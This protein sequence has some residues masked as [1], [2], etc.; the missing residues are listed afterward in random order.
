MTKSRLAKKIIFGLIFSIIFGF[1]GN[2]L[3]GKYKIAESKTWYN[4]LYILDITNNENTSKIKNVGI[5][6]YTRF[7]RDQF[8]SSLQYTLMIF[9]RKNEVPVCKAINIQTV[10]FSIMIESGKFIESEKEK[11]TFCFSKILSDSFKRFKEKLML[12]V[13]NA[14]M[15]K[16]VTLNELRLEIDRIRLQDLSEDG[17]QLNLLDSATPVLEK[18]F[19]KDI[20]KLYENV[21]ADVN[22]Y[23]ET[24][25]QNRNLESPIIGNF[26]VLDTLNRLSNECSKIL[27]E[28]QYAKLIN[29]LTNQIKETR[30][31][32]LF[33][34]LD[35]IFDVTK[36]SIKLNKTRREIYLTKTQTVATFLILGFIVGFILSANN[37]VLLNRNK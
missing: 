31:I 37:L 30:D 27:S 9:K 34:A 22:I 7:V 35:Q 29:E 2:F 1:M 21:I 32:I 12:I 24:N 25:N 13:E 3:H 23:L 11:L 33:T 28:N 8:F 14:L 18:S 4:E 36:Q 20:D 26:L 15:S 17:S 6:N 19:C 16:Q 10:D 5:V